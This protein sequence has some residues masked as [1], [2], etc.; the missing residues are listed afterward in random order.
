MCAS[1]AAQSPTMAHDLVPDAETAL[2]VGLAILEA[3]YGKT[4][5][6]DGQPYEAVLQGDQWWIVP[7]TAPGMRGGGKPELSLSKKDAR[8]LS[9]SLSK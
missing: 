7:H 3:S 4:L 5:V 8:V 6:D 2:K 1:V 9:I